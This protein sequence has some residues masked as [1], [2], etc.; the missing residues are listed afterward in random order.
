MGMGLMAIQV[1]NVEG[2]PASPGQL[3]GRALLLAVDVG[4]TPLIGLVTML[5]SS[6]NQR[7]VSLRPLAPAGIGLNVRFLQ[8]RGSTRPLPCRAWGEHHRR[9]RRPHRARRRPSDLGR[10]AMAMRLLPVISKGFDGVSTVLRRPGNVALL[11]G[12]STLV[13]VAYLTTLYFRTQVFVGVPL[14]MSCSANHWWRGAGA[15]PFT[16]QLRP[17]GCTE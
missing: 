7:I 14:V 13:T 16:S 3:F 2:S 5:V 8:K 4:I 12:G 11:L 9:A 15:L 17:W 10:S 6:R 1:V